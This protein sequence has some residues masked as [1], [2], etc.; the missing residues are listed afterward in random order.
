MKTKTNSKLNTN[1][2]SRDAMFDVIEAKA[3]ASNKVSGFSAA[4]HAEVEFVPQGKRKLNRNFFLTFM[5]KKGVLLAKLEIETTHS[6]SPNLAEV[7][8]TEWA[9]GKALRKQIMKI[10]KKT[11]TNPKSIIKFLDS[12]VG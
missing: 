4:I 8:E 5:E 12:L 11:Q 9:N 10:A 2:L 6:S 7:E 1:K 3:L